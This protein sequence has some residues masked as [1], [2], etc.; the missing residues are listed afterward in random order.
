[1]LTFPVDKAITFEILMHPQ[2][3]ENEDVDSPHGVL[4]D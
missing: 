2:Y 1:M 4:S 3:G